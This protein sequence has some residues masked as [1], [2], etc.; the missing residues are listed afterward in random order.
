MWSRIFEAKSGIESNMKKSWILTGNI[1]STGL[2]TFNISAT[3]T[4]PDA[5]NAIGS[6]QVS[7]AP[8][9]KSVGEPVVLVVYLVSET[10]QYGN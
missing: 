7:V 3:E 4:N 9:L 10:P 1:C 5:T 2:V 8:G 6:G